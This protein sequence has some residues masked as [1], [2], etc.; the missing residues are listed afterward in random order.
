MLKILVQIASSRFTK[1]TVLLLWAWSLTLTLKHGWVW[2]SHQVVDKGLVV[3]RYL[4]FD[5]EHTPMFVWLTMILLGYAAHVFRQRSLGYYG[6]VEI[7][8]G[9]IGGFV[10]I[11]KLPLDQGPAW[12]GLVASAFIIVRGAGNVSQALSEQEPKPRKI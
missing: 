11:G 9:L 7:L 1:L 4:Y 6:L 8:C 5:I 3:E 10:A 2:E 12:F